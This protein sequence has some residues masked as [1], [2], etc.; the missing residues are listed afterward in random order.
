MK[1]YFLIHP[2]LQ[3]LISY[4]YFLL[5][6]SNYTSDDS[7]NSGFEQN[8][9]Y[10]TDV[11]DLLVQIS[12]FLSLFFCILGFVH[13]CQSPWEEN[14]SLTS[15][16]QQLK[17]T[18]STCWSCLAG[19]KIWLFPK[20]LPGILLFHFQCITV[21]VCTLLLLL[22]STGCLGRFIFTLKTKLDSHPLITNSPFF[23]DREW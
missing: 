1:F 9:N 20:T 19:N 2:P 23:L 17:G 6:F 8:D 14:S 4:S 22:W 21:L 15:H 16:F 3:F 12:T 10:L 11:K 18:A 7:L 13:F 5:I